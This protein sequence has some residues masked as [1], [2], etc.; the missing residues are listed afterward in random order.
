MS[1][2]R[3]CINE[4]LPIWK[5]CLESPF[6]ARLEADTLEEEC[7]KGY[8]VDDSLYL[9]EY[10]KVFAWGMTKAST[11]AEIK[12]FYS[13]LSFVNAGEGN[14]RIKYLKKW[15]LDDASIQHLPLRKANADYVHTMLTEAQ[16][17]SGVPECMMAALPCVISYSWIF[18]QMAARTPEVL[19]GKYADLVKDY[20]DADYDA[21][22]DEWISFTDAACEG[23][24]E[25]QL[26]HCRDIFKKCSQHELNFWTM[27]N[28]AREDV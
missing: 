25:E 13:L 9:R 26:E 1:F 28:R 8:I 12:A 3:E 18:K 20:T 19:N 6:L 24:S 5:Q 15:G 16:N 11:L 2:V 7:F 22:C 4:C 21:V 14:T 27:S 10:A 23:L 17:G